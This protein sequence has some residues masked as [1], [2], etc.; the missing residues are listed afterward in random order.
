MNFLFLLYLKGSG[1]LPASPV[2]PIPRELAGLLRG[3]PLVTRHAPGGGDQ[4]VPDRL[5]ELADYE[6]EEFT[7]LQIHQEEEEEGVM[8]VD[9][10]N[11]FSLEEGL[12]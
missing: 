1:F 5:K 3:S 2:T 11:D 7:S 6:A 8:D 10:S 12:E 9:Q 4:T